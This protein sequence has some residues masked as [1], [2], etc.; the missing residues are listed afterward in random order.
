MYLL[1]KMVILHN[2]PMSC[3]SGGVLFW[4]PPGHHLGHGFGGVRCI[5]G[6][7]DA[8]HHA[9]TLKMIIAVEG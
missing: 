2:F 4:I 5:D 1:L 9:G 3:F 8:A 6:F 7:A